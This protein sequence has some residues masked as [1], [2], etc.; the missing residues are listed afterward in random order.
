MTTNVRN[1]FVVIQNQDVFI[2]RGKTEDDENTPLFP[3]FTESE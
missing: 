1:I 2:I 3:Y